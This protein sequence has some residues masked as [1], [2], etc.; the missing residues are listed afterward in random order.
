[1]EALV[2]LGRAYREKIQVKAKI[3][4]KT[5]TVIQRDKKVLDTLRGFEILLRRRAQRLQSIRY[6]VG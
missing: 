1:M 2:L 6:D 5:M 3:P 4:L